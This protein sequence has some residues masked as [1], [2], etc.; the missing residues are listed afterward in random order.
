MELRKFLGKSRTLFEENDLHHRFKQS[1]ESS[2][3]FVPKNFKATLLFEDFSKAFDSI[4]RGKMN[5]LLLAYGLKKNVAARMMLHRNAKVK[6]R[7]P[8]GDTDFFDVVAEIQ[9]GDR[10]P[11]YLFIIYLDYVLRTSIDIKK[12]LIY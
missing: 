3:E 10:F 2:K 5:Q 9:Q 7:S 8:D 4:H 1:M 12:M 6:V 11:P